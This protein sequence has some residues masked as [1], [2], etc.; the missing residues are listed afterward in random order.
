MVTSHR[1]RNIP[2]EQR[3]APLALAPSARFRCE[4]GPGGASRFVVATRS[5]GIFLK[6][7]FSRESSI[8]ER[9]REPLV[10]PLAF[11]LLHILMGVQGGYYDCR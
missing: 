5:R 9:S 11:D 3:K 1:P 7:A 10:D 2:H 8:A 6:S 4:H